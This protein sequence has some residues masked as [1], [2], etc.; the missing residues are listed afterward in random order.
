MN[1]NLVALTCFALIVTTTKAWSVVPNRNTLRS[2]VRNNADGI[3]C[4]DAGDADRVDTCRKNISRREL[5]HKGIATAGVS[6]MTY[7]SFAQAATDANEKTEPEGKEGL[8]TASA[9]AALLHP[10]PTF[11]IVDKKGVPFTVVGEDAKVTGYFFTTYKEA[12]RILE[13]ARKS[14]DK[15]IA[16]AKADKEEDIGANPWINARI[17][18]V[19]LDYAITLVSKSMR[20]SGKGVYFK[21]AP[22]EDDIDD[23]LAMTGDD[24]LAEGKVPLFYYEDFKASDAEGTEKTPLYFRKN[25]LEKEWRRLNPGQ[26]PPK[27]NVTELLSVLTELVRPGGSDD[28]LRNLMFVSPKESESKQKECLKKGGSEPAFVVGKRIIVL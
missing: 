28:E 14:A 18:T 12:Q 27:V 4:K 10:V 2:S 23:A 7:P 17:S 15:A 24:D 16:K 3:Q 11:T 1:Y 13:L 21:M 8:M 20:M 5:L 26:T 19:P 22:A 6:L 25:E 9:V